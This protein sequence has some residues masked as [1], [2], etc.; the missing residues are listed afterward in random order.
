M[1]GL[2]EELEQR[3][4]Q[5][6]AREELWA[7]ERSSLEQQSR[8]KDAQIERLRADAKLAQEQQAELQRLLEL[9]SLEASKAH[10]LQR[11]GVQRQTELSVEVCRV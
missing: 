6:A 2:E 7:K 11:Q 4:H 1:Q 3:R 8:D 9:Q 10:D 5:Q